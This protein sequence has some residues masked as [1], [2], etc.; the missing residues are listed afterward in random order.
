V[1]LITLPKVKVKLQ[2][3]QPAN[4]SDPIKLP[5]PASVK[6]RVAQLS[7]GPR[8]DSVVPFTP[9]RWLELEAYRPRVLIGDASDLQRL[10]EQVQLGMFDLSCVDRAIVVLTRYR[11]APLRDISRVTLWQ[12]FGVPIFE[13]YLGPDNGVL[14]AE[15]GAH[16]GWHLQPGAYCSHHNGELILDSPGNYGLCTGLAATIDDSACPC[17]QTTSRLMNV[18]AI[19]RLAYPRKIP[20]SAASQRRLA[21]SA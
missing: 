9:E 15:C 18:E 11:V 16:E 4:P 6:L 20:A 8:F 2:R 17:G 5:F 19:S 1:A 13:L 7:E 14:A 12:G 10:L 21:A 3:S